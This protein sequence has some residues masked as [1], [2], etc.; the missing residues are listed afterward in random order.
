[1]PVLHV[2]GHRAHFTDSG[3]VG[4]TVVIVP[5]ALGS[6]DTW[7]AVAG[8]LQPRHRVLTVDL[9]GAGRT[10][11]WSAPTP[12]TLD[13]EAAIVTEVIASRCGDPVALLGHSYGAAVAL[14]AALA[15][16][17]YV[18]S[19]V[20]V[21]PFM[22]E[23]LRR[24]GA[25]DL[26]RAAR[27]GFDGFFAAF[28]AGDAERAVRDWFTAYMP[29]PWTSL[30]APARERLVAAAETIRAGNRAL[31]ADPTRPDALARL[32]APALVVS[33]GATLPLFRD[34]ARL[35]AR[36]L[37]R[38]HHELLAG[39][40]HLLYDDRPR[41]LAAAV[42]TH[43]SP[44]AP[45]PSGAPP[46]PSPPAR[47]RPRELRSPLPLGVYEFDPLADPRFL[48]STRHGAAVP[49]P[50]T[51]P[52]FVRH[53]DP[54]LGPEHLPS[55]VAELTPLG[56]GGL[57]L[58]GNRHVTDAALPALAPLIATAEHLGLSATP[59]TDAGLAQLPPASSSLL[60]LDLGGTPITGDCTA[61]IA[62]LPHLEHLRL[63]WTAVTDDAV[64][65]L[66]SLPHLRS[67]DLTATPV[68][69]AAVAALARL[70]TL[71]VLILAQTPVTDAAIAALGA[72]CRALRH[73]DLA[74]TRVT[75]AILPT[76]Q[77]LET[78]VVRGTAIARQQ[79]GGTR[80]VW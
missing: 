20:L 68:S 24:A 11:R 76:L 5:G 12:M 10:E 71:E 7:R 13:D 22:L 41:E 14:R 61:W 17:A 74:Y 46:A 57:C 2:D 25:H 35:V 58:A 30:P 26:Y 18:A 27:R 69:D 50:P 3:G 43:I 39:G 53:D 33:G 21:E 34:V 72:G 54:E 23:V 9:H 80:L 79:R 40:T 36:L 73:L 1:M 42:A 31:L 44:P 63:G 6:T 60:T 47:V 45:D 28:D 16:P 70:P 59:I 49:L 66:A 67:L 55:L 75:D 37:P 4:P 77:H 38:A 48:G 32:T 8:A 78:L 64:A 65:H 62:R 51:A 52:W 19:L 15:K 29:V 56:T